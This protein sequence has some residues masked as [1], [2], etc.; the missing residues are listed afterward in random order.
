MPVAKF[1]VGQYNILANCLAD[2]LKP[3][4]WYGYRGLSDGEYRADA[5]DPV[6]RQLFGSGRSTKLM[7]FWA[8]MKRFFKI[9]HTDFP[10]LLHLQEYSLLSP[11]DDLCAKLQVALREFFS[12]TNLSSPEGNKDLPYQLFR[13]HTHAY[14]LWEQ[15]ASPVGFT[16]TAD[17]WA[18]LND[19]AANINSAVDSED[20][21]VAIRAYNAELQRL[22]GV[23]GDFHARLGALASLVCLSDEDMHRVLAVQA[24]WKWAT[25]AE[26]LIAEIR[27]HEVDIWGIEEL[28]AVDLFRSQLADTHALAIF[29][30]RSILPKE[31]GAAIFYNTRH[32]Q[33]V[34]GDSVGFVRFSGAAAL[35]HPE[36]LPRQISVSLHDGCAASEND[37]NTTTAQCPGWV[38][39]DRLQPHDKEFFDE[40]IAVFAALRHVET[41]ATVVV[42][43][44]HLNHTQN[45]PLRE[46]IRRHQARQLDLALRQFVRTLHLDGAPTVLLG[47][48]NDVPTLATYGRPDGPSPVYDYLVNES[49]WQDAF[50]PPHQPTTFTL[51]R[52]Y[53]IDFI[54]FKPND[55]CLTVAPD[56]VQLVRLVGVVDG[57]PQLLPPHQYHAACL[58]PPMPAVD[59][60]GPVPSDHVPI[61]ATLTMHL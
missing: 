32:F 29:K 26:R 9:Y 41:G 25:R 36:L 21:C 19:L 45:D 12:R 10:Y 24:E 57:R 18:G 11:A 35:T 13:P 2:N 55:R 42:V 56:P 34:T 40:R 38:F 27:R 61:T 14:Q 8:L 47:D 17:N 44:T 33:L 53:P 22:L 39:T 20:K 30:H 23:G 4:F 50:K 28:D 6:R 49:G 54:L 59:D 16:L 37:P 58:G 31:D 46:S 52:Q 7:D 1:R 60:Q 43:S 51:N 48:F 3:W 15:V 5:L